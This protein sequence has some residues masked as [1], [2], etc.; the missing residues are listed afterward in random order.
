ML[1]GNYEQILKLISESSSIPQD[2]IERRIEAKRAKLSGLISKEGAAQ[3]LASELGISFDKQKMKISGLLPGMRRINLTGQIV[4][5]N[6]IAE[7]NKNGKSGKIGSFLLADD[8]SNVRVVLWDTNHISLLEKGIIKEG[9]VVELS[10]TDIRNS[11]IHVGSFGDIKLSQTLIDNVQT[12]PVV[13]K[14]AIG[15]MQSNDNVVTRAFVVQIFGPTFYNV[16][17]ECKKRVSETSQCEVHGVVVPKK[18]AILTLIIDD[19]SG[20]IRAV[21]FSEQIK[22]I[23]TE[24]ELENSEAFMPKRA[25]LLGKEIIV[26]GGVRKNKL[27]ENPEIFVNEVRDINLDELIKELEA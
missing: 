26:E 8:T 4:K 20:S 15:E 11:E 16:C 25:E 14:K 24:A 19:G 10:N 17:P 3:I 2:E 1:Q 12:K 27:T 21:L 13:H 23:A 5:I 18:N 7:Y 6:R 22:K 9:D